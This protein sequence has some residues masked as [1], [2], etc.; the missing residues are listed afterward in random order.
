MDAQCRL[1]SEQPFISR[2]RQQQLTTTT[3]A[4]ATTTATVYL[5]DDLIEV[6]GGVEHQKLHG[7]FFFILRRLLSGGSPSAPAA[8]HTAT[9]AATPVHLLSTERGE[10]AAIPLREPNT[11]AEH[12][13]G[14]R[15]L[16]LVRGRFHS[17]IMVFCGNG[18][19]ALGHC[20]VIS[21]D[22]GCWTTV[23]QVPT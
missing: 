19:S 18:M 14:L 8:S 3:A 21:I 16:C 1:R 11:K 6:Y 15:M 7:R 5:L 2:Q 22:F 9:T 23:K 4:A 12:R 13:T 20:C 17:G 10:N